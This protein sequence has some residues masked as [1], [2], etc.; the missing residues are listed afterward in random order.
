MYALL[1]TALVSQA[2]A[3]TLVGGLDVPRLVAETPTVLR[4]IVFDTRTERI[5]DGSLRTEY[6]VE[7]ESALRG[8]APELLRVTLPGGRKGDIIQ[9]FFGVPLLEEGDEVVLFVNDE[10]NV[11]LKG[12]LTVDGD[13][14]VDGFERPT[15]P[16]TIQELEDAVA[17]LHR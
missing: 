14:L 4:G 8:E 12:I 7:I 13:R 9:R 6:T 10:G 1:L 5:G 11:P 3:A 15:M 17:A 2:H 16:T